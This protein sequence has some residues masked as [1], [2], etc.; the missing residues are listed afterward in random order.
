MLVGLI[1]EICVEFWLIGN[2]GYYISNFIFK[3]L[4]TGALYFSISFFAALKQ[5]M[6]VL[7]IVIQFCL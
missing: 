1:K 4:N 5:Q 2:Y 7:K 6:D 3:A